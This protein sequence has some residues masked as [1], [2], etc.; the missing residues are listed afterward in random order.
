MPN[1]MFNIFFVY[2]SHTSRVGNSQILSAPGIF[3]ALDF[4]QSSRQLQVD[5]T[6]PSVIY[7]R[8]WHGK[9]LRNLLLDKILRNVLNHI[10]RRWTSYISQLLFCYTLLQFSQ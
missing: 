10:D 1:I 6:V 3:V 2:D 9:T 5:L 8:L 4:P 7:L